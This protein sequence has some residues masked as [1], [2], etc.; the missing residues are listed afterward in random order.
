VDV[1]TIRLGDWKYKPKVR[2]DL[3]TTIGL[4]LVLLGG[5][6]GDLE[7]VGIEDTI[8]AVCTSTDLTAV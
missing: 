6:F 8:G 3:V 2:D 7:L 5:A 4:F 1:S